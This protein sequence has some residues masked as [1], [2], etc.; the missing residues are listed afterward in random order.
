MKSYPT[1]PRD[2][3]RDAS[4]FAFDKLDGS[5]IRVEWSMKRGFYKFGSRTQLIDETSKQFGEAIHILKEKY[6][7]DL[8]VVFKENRWDNVVCFFEYYGKNSFA[9]NHEDEPHTLTLFDVNLYKKGLLPP[10]EF[11]GFFG[12]LDV[13]KV[14][15]AGKAN[16]DLIKAVH[17]STLEDMT[18]E[19]VVCKGAF[20]RKTGMPTMFKIKSNAWIDKLKTYCNGNKDLMA[21][22]L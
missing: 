11:L 10:K 19:G 1:I 15:Y 6:A 5:N 9:G 18:F 12:H 13:P 17:D 2:Y 20:N 3:D 16:Q 22:L 8:E 7:S 4:I 21:R 14:L